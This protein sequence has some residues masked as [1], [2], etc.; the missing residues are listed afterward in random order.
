M[1]LSIFKKSSKNALQ[2]ESI[3]GFM[4][5]RLGLYEKALTHKSEGEESNYERLEF[6]GDALLDAIV[7]EYIYIKYPLKDEGEL[8]KLKSKLV[9]RN[10]L[11]QLGVKLGLDELLKTNLKKPTKSVYGNALEALIGAVYLDRGYKPTKIFV[12]ERV[13]KPHVDIDEVAV[14]ESDFKSRILEWSQREKKKME[15]EDEIV[16]SG[17]NKHFIVKLFIDNQLKGKAESISKK[18]AE[19]LACEQFFN[20]LTS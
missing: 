19:Q 17:K 5:R 1:P 6:L 7:A 15:L 3:L 2:L 20:E 18:K 4:P 11:T 16:G 10:S 13:F 14:T 9:S 12:I 8:T